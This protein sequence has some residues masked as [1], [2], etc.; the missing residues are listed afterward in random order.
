MCALD[1]HLVEVGLGISPVPARPVRVGA[2]AL[3]PLLTGIAGSS[4]IYPLII[5]FSRH[6]LLHFLHFTFASSDLGGERDAIQIS[7]AER[8]S[9]PIIFFFTTD[10]CLG[11]RPVHGGRA[12][13]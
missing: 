9:N 7:P 2:V 12:V 6:A 8:G 10:P 3:N 11:A 5:L 13:A 4:V 1:N